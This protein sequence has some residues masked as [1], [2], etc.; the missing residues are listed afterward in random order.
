MFT[1]KRLDFVYCAR[2]V[3]DDKTVADICPDSLAKQTQYV[4]VM[5]YLF[6]R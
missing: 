6:M 5:T 4:F 3:S 2:N 1:T